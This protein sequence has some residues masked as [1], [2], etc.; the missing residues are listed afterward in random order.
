MWEG[1]REVWR[2]KWVGVGVTGGNVATWQ[3]RSLKGQPGHKSSF[4]IKW[5]IISL[6]HHITQN[7]RAASVPPRL[8]GLKWS[9]DLRGHDAAW[10]TID[11]LNPKRYS[12]VYMTVNLT[13]KRSAVMAM[14]V[15]I[16]STLSGITRGATS[17]RKTRK[18]EDF[19]VL[20]ECEC[21]KLTRHVPW[22]STWQR[23]SLKHSIFGIFPSVRNLSE[24]NRLMDS[25]RN[26]LPGVMSLRL[27]EKRSFP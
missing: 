7:N 15:V 10:R 26:F 23:L 18:T 21:C 3:E 25:N 5:G 20:Y 8:T 22:F 4:D 27:Q 13:R 24:R 17:V 16:Q 11:V 14:V 2:S 1:E 6:L 9:K 19:K 12:R